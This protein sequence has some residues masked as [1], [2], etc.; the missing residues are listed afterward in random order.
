MQ[1]TES[2][3]KATT[4]QPTGSVSLSLKSLNL[5]DYVCMKLCP[6]L[7]FFLFFFSKANPIARSCLPG[8]EVMGIA[9]VVRENMT[10]CVTV[11]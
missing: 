4:L 8:A 2:V 1:K 11:V 7:F 10:V 3:S 6:F 9:A 5:V